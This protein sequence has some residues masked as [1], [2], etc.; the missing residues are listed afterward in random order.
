[1]GLSREFFF[2]IGLLVGGLS[3][4][5]IFCFVWFVDRFGR[6]RVYII[7]TLIGT[8]SVFFFFMAFEV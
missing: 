4:L 8:L 6:R 3:C 5:I 2:N 7:G 1:M